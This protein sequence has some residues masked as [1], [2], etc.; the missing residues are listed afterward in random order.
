MTP[1]YFTDVRTQVVCKYY[2]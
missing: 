2:E 1:L